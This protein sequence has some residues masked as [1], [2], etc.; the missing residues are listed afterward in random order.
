MSESRHPFTFGV[1]SNC[2][3]LGRLY[4]K[5]RICKHCTTISYKLHRGRDSSESSEGVFR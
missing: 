2:G 1:C 3:R 5:W 4:G